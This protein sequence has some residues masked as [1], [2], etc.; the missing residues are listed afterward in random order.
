MRGDPP[1]RREA[2][3]RIALPVTSRVDRGG[4]HREA[5]GNN[6]IAAPLTHGVNSSG[7]GGYAGRRREDDVNLVSHPLMAKGNCSFDSTLETYALP[8]ATAPEAIRRLLPVECERLQGF[9]DQYTAIQYRGKPAAD[10]PRYRAL[11]NSMAV[12]VMRW[13]GER[14]VREVEGRA[15]R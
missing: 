15:A 5:H 10:G 6:L 11:G 9:P 4:E 2:G 8:E 7:R 13:I 1:P 3:E 14:I 12:T